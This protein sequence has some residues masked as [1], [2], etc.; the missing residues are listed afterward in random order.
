ME[1]SMG[2]PIAVLLSSAALAALAATGASAMPIAPSTAP[3]LNVEQVRW[4]C[5]EWGAAGTSGTM[6]VPMGTIDA[7]T[8]TNGES[9]IDTAP[10]MAITVHVGTKDMDGAAVRMT[11]SKVTTNNEPPGVN[12]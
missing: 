9:V 4:V 3:A 1:A 2:K 10:A 7:M 5:N 6:T 11:T 8:M 12:V